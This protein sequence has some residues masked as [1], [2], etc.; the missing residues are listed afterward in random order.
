MTEALDNIQQQSIYRTLISMAR[1]EKGCIA[2]FSVYFIFILLCCTTIGF[3]FV[4]AAFIVDGSSAYCIIFLFV[5]ILSILAV[6]SML[7]KT[8]AKSY[9]NETVT[10]TDSKASTS[11]NTEEIKRFER[12][13]SSKDHKSASYDE[14]NEHE[15]PSDITVPTYF[16]LKS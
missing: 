9:S 1:Y 16:L 2:A 14:E 11:L 7:L 4:V 5:V 15:I 3:P 10:S 8:V 12:I 13:I 6:W